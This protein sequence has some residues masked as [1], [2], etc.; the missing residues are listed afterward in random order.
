MLGVSCVLFT[1]FWIGE[2]MY[3]GAKKRAPVEP[4]FRMIPGPNGTQILQKRVA[5]HGHHH[6]HH[7]D[8]AAAPGTAV[9]DRSRDVHGMSAQVMSLDEE[10]Y[11]EVLQE[12]LPPG[13]NMDP[14][15]ISIAQMSEEEE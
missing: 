14:E 12:P 1:F 5:S 3:N 11:D 8:H 9:Y 2:T 4:V 13:T 6:G 10:E 15:G 7:H